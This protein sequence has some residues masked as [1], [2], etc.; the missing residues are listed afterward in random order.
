MQIWLWI[1]SVSAAK[2]T[3]SVGF[4]P[5]FEF[6][7]EV[8]GENPQKIHSIN[9]HAAD[10][11]STLWVNLFADSEWMC[12]ELFLAHSHCCKCNMPQIFHNKNHCRR[13]AACPPFVSYFVLMIEPTKISN[14][15][16]YGVLIDILILTNSHLWMLTEDT[17]KFIS[18]C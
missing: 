4:I 12:S 1:H 14:Y 8:S 3:T 18:R 17:T 11:K 6:P 2:A 10:I 5:D 16:L 15:M 13:S 7:I 9:W